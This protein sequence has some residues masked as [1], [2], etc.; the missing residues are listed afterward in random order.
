MPRLGEVIGAL[1]ADAVQARLQADLE[2]VRIAEAYSRDDLLRHLPVPR[3][4]VPEITIDIPLLVSQ[5]ESGEQSGISGTH[6]D[7][8]EI[9]RAVG[10]GLR[11]AGI[12]LS[13][14]EP[15]KI[16]SAAF[17]RMKSVT[18]PQEFP[19]NPLKLP[20]ELARIVEDAVRSSHQDIADDRLAR[21]RQS[22]AGTLRESLAQ[23]AIPSP[24]LQVMAEASAIK[25][26]EDRES[27][28]HVRLTITEDDYAV[29]SRDADQGFYLTPE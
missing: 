1:L 19:R 12:K 27:V 3:F 29:V 9:N 16:S 28:L 7:Y 6:F 4:R 22:L 2:A 21:L 5:V 26:H 18:D 14:G 20:D 11:S 23:K 24:S 13:P 25:S 10:V 17:K 8:A 15:S